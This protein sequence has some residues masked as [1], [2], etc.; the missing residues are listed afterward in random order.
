MQ[1]TVLGR[2]GLQVSRLGFGCMRLPMKSDTEVDRSLAIPMLQR[3]VELGVSYFD[4]A[5]GYCGGDSQR[6]LG[7]AM[8]GVREKVVLSTKNPH[9][10]KADHKG[11]WKNLEDSL[12]RLRTD[13]IDIYNHHGLN[14]ETYQ[15]SLAGDDGLYALALKAKEQGLIRHI[16]HSFHGPLASL[17]SIVSSGLFDS[18]TLQYNLLD[19]SLEEGIALAR[20]LGEGVV[21]MGPVGGG[22]LGF[23]SDKARELVG[24]VKST[25]ELALRFVLSNPGVCVAL[26]GMST[27]TQLEENVATADASGELSAEEHARIEDAIQERKKLSGLYC[28]G[29]NYCMPCPDGVDIP[30]NFEILNHER[31]FGLKDYARSRYA[32]LGGK[33]AL[34]RLC[35]KCV[36]L[37]PQKLAI[38]ERLADAVT[39]LDERAGKVGSW[40]EM[41]GARRSAS[42]GALEVSLRY[43]VKNYTDRKLERVA[44]ELA[45]H[46]EE[47]IE[48]ARFELLGVREFGRRH[49]DVIL[50]L[51][52]YLDGFSIDAHMEAEGVRTLE[53]FG[54]IVA[55]ATRSEAPTVE[56]RVA[57]SLHVPGPYHPVHVAE[58][59][60]VGHG[61]DFALRFDNERLWIWA[62]VED[63]LARPLSGELARGVRADFFRIFVDARAPE[64][65]G[66]GGYADGVMH[67]SVYPRESEG[68]VAK[69]SRE[70]EVAAAARRTDDG[71]RLV[72]SMPWKSLHASGA[73][74]VLGFDCAVISHDAAGAEVVRLSWTGRT[75]QE[76]ATEGF[77][78]VLLVQD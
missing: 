77:G 29:C 54:S 17:K 15:A 38:P 30:S 5:V 27:L 51:A 34:C 64:S 76:R 62:D 55:V 39:L 14:W 7:E 23:P 53:H 2:T 75:N 37:C 74:A 13:H 18:V 26:S 47:G 78:R 32:A 69:P 58:K 56:A 36:P 68:A 28:T 50:D 3:A 31:I 42:T 59:K 6:V 4:T 33:A 22:R 21:V 65:L 35:G 60:P 16:C 1:Y 44:V 57:P 71:Y 25:P 9:Y 12:E 19:R 66:R 46:R 24:E 52:P 43:Q 10:D 61:F 48:P 49:R 73:P 40:L 67:V 70:V 63:D 45:G 20:E 8:Q 41:R 11:W 72:C